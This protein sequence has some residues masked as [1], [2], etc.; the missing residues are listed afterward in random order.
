ME[1]SQAGTEP[2]AITVRVAGIEGLPVRLSAVT[3]NA[4]NERRCITGRE[5]TGQQDTC[6]FGNLLPGRY[7]IAPEGL[8][9]S[10]PADLFENENLMI[11]FDLEVLPPGITGWQAHLVKNSSD[12]KATN[13]AAATIRARVLGQPGLV[14]ALRSARGTERFCAVEPNPVLGSPV[15]EF[16]ELRPGVYLVEVL[17]TGASLRLFVDGVGLAD[18]EFAPN[19]TY[20]TQVLAQTP[21]VVGQGAQPSSSLTPTPTPALLEVASDAVLP[22]TATPTVTLAPTPALAWQGRV[23]ETVN[24]VAGAIGVRAVGLKDHPVILSSGSWQSQVL[25]TGTKA[26]LGDYA[27]EFGGL[28]QGEYTINLVD[29]A[30]LT[31][32]LGPNQYMLVEFRY[33]FVQPQ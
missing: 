4:G 13:E 27:V 28:A 10:L 14:V 23:V 32:N 2:A 20:A 16:G 22:A 21:P 19:A 17:N 8:G 3:S 9:V 30:E 31:V 24:G 26:E 18:I 11:V 33:D 12:F 7:T 5:A 15:C 29:L 6:T 1:R 25:F